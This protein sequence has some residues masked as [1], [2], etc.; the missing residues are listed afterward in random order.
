[1]PRRRKPSGRR[2]PTSESPP[3][4][5]RRSTAPPNS[6]R[7]RRRSRPWKGTSASSCC[8]DKLDAL[9]GARREGVTSFLGLDA[10]R[11]GT[12]LFRLDL[13][14]DAAYPDPLPFADTRTH[15]PLFSPADN[16]RVLHATGL[17]Q[18][19]R[20]SSFCAACGAPADL[21]DGGTGRRCSSCGVPS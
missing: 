14:A 7:S 15:A 10:D 19:Q 21:V 12:P 17:A 18:W 8:G 20:R 13:P 9:L 3:P 5:S 2:R 11:A 4:P 16:A 6:G 1:M